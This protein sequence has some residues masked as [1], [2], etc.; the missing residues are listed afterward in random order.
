MAIHPRDLPD[1]LRNLPPETTKSID[2]LHNISDVT[3]QVPTSL[4]VQRGYYAHPWPDEIEGLGRHRVGPFDHCVKCG[5]GTWARYGVTVLCV[6]CA[7][8]WT[9]RG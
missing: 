9:R 2:N 6:T 4:R 8:E 3:E 1:L 5:V 7:K